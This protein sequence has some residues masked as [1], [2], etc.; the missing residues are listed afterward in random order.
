MVLCAPFPIPISAR[1]SSWLTRWCGARSRC[2]SRRFSRRARSPG[3]PITC[4]KWAKCGATTRRTR[5]TMRLAEL[6]VRSATQ[7]YLTI[8]AIALACDGSSPCS[9]G[10]RSRNDFPWGPWLV[11]GATASFLPWEL[12]E[13]YR[14]LKLG[15]LVLLMLNLAVVGYL[16]RRK[17]PRAP[18]ST[19]QRATSWGALAI[20]LWST[21]AAASVL[22]AAIPPLQL[23]AMTFG[24]ASLLSLVKWTTRRESIASHLRQPL[25]AWLVGCGG[26]F[27]YHLLYFLALRMA[28]PAEANVVN[29]LWPMFIILFAQALPG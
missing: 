14:H 4:A 8:G 12:L 22:V 28:P 16:V 15:R 5:L 9:K 29:Y 19:R 3:G 18:M 17:M 21:L 1:A 20:A 27:G 26:L 13:L 11:V 6:V 25:G 23:M 7:R 2:C 10:G 24:V